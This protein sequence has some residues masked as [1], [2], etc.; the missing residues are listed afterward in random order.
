MVEVRPRRQSPRTLGG[1]GSGAT[2]R[3][4]TA[5]AGAVGAISGEEKAVKVEK[6]RAEGVE[7]IQTFPFGGKRTSAVLWSRTS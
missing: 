6:Q 5:V 7:R 2:L 3:A 4:V 1:A